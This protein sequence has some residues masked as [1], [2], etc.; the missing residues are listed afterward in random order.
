MSFQKNISNFI[1]RNVPIKNDNN[2]QKENYQELV[3]KAKKEF[4]IKNK[5]DSSLSNIVGWKEAGIGLLG[6]S[7]VYPTATMIPVLAGVVGVGAVANKLLDKL[8]EKD[9]VNT[10][11]KKVLDSNQDS[12]GKTNEKRQ[13]RYQKNKYWY[14]Y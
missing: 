9:Y 8:M 6:I 1:N 5:K 14:F 7:I 11:L 4:K 10:N 12:V 2:S 3:E 13:S